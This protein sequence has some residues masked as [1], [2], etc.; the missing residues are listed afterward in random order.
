MK[1][2]EIEAAFLHSVL[3]SDKKSVWRDIVNKTWEIMSQELPESNY[4]LEISHRDRLVGQYDA[5]L[6]SSWELWNNFPDSVEKGSNRI[7]D[8]WKNEINGKA[9]LVLDALSLRETPWILE[10]A[11]KR[12]YKIEFSG[13]V[14]SELPSETTEF[15]K[16]I[17]FPQRSALTQTETNSSHVLPNT[18]TASCD[19]PWEDCIPLVE[20]KE[21][22]VFWH[23]WPDS[24]MHD[25]SEPGDGFQTLVKEAKTKLGSDEFWS[26]IE[27]LTTGRKL[28]ITSD[29]GYAASSLF[30]DVTDKEQATYLKETFK[31]GRCLRDGK[32]SDK[33]APPLEVELNG[34]NNSSFSFVLGRRKWKSAGGYPTLLHGGLTLLEVL[35]PFIVISR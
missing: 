20:A 25:L 31:S 1:K 14:S 6:L 23:H 4:D 35:T 17:G 29:H 26:F 8:F 33:W 21:N 13:P 5:A 22:F 30:Y 10:G 3:T 2:Q 32:V 19:L 12:G 15:A 18:K 7:I 24:R 34:S 28:V 11:K 9:L 16:A 27:R